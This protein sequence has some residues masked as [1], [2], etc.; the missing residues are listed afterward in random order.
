VA[1]RLPAQSFLS[2]AANPQSARSIE[3][4]LEIDI[5]TVPISFFIQR[6]FQRPYALPKNYFTDHGPFLSQVHV[7]NELSPHRK[8]PGSVVS[9]MK[10]KSKF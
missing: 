1:D 10:E 6:R 2:A 3:K 5:V 9:L 8:L 4:S 7:Q